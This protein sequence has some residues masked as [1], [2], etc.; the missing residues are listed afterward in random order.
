[1]T[2]HPADNPRL[3]EVNVTGAYQLLQ[4]AKGRN[5][6][7]FVFAS[8]GEVYPE[9]NPRQLP[10]T[11][12]HPTLPNSPYGMS[13]LLGETMVRNIAEQTGMPCTILRFSHT[14]VAEE[15][16]DPNSFFSGPRFYVNAKIRQ[17]QNLPQSPAV[18]Q[19]IADLQAVAT[20][21]EQH[22]ISLDQDGKPFRMG[23]CDARDMCQGITLALTH[24]DAVGETFNIGAEHAFYFDEAVRH[25]AQ[26]TGLPVVDVRLSTTRYDY[27]TSV[28]KAMRVLG[29]QP[30]YDIFRMI[31]EVAA[32]R[33]P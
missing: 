25:L 12:E 1:M 18:A 17:L 3:F 2:W 23:M 13:K 8:S 26:Y 5:L 7:R 9:L 22:Y 31:D 16:F 4:A 15:L 33:Q 21:S 6:S 27:E 28:D 19:T 30:A 29:Y 14:Q 32:V 20:G 11:E 10:I 24:P